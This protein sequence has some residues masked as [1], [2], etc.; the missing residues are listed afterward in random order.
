ML[1]EV[2][3][4]F[5]KSLSGKKEREKTGM[6]VVEGPPSVTMALESG[7]AIE[8]LV[9]S[10][11]FYNSPS[12]ENVMR[13]LEKGPAVR[14]VFTVPDELYERMS[15]T[16]SPQGVLCVASV[17]F[18]FR[19]A[20]PVSP[21]DEPLEVLGVDIQDPGNVGT[22][23]RAAAAVGASSVVFLGRSA[24]PFSPKCIRASA[25][26]V[27]RVAVQG[28]DRHIEPSDYVLQRHYAGMSVFKTVPRGGISPWEA[29][30]AGASS[31]VFGNE[32]KGL[33]EDVLSLPGQDISIPMLGGTESL[34]VAVASGMILYEAL[35]QRTRE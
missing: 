34:N 11:S 15:E 14:Q 3:W 16:K 30:F 1:R 33:G 25:G 27:F 26:T 7:V 17:P 35:R 8:Y 13:L 5:I 24:D 9:M 6:T 23:V 29:D 12:G 4:R 2:P 20:M 32:A 21:W 31:L 10:R 22:L 19:K 28:P 18:R